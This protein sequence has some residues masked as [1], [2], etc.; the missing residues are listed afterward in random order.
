MD[1]NVLHSYGNLSGLCGRCGHEIQLYIDLPAHLGHDVS[2][3]AATEYK[4]QHQ[5]V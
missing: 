4:Q 5:Y 1:I 3:R 2:I